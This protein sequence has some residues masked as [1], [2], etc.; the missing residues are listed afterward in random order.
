MGPSAIPRKFP[1]II[2]GTKSYGGNSKEH[3]YPRPQDYSLY[4]RVY[5]RISQSPQET[6]T[7]PNPTADQPHE[8]CSHPPPPCL[9]AKWSKRELPRVSKPDRKTVVPNCRAKFGI[10]WNPNL[11]HHPR[12]SLSNAPPN[13]K[14]WQEQRSHPAHM[15]RPQTRQAP[16]KQ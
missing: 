14:T 16:T 7:R 9:R 11:T 12:K 6:G 2:L 8:Q 1:A 3:N 5:Q 15:T 13:P 4:Y 10:Y